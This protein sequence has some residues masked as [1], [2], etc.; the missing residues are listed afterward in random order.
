MITFKNTV[1]F[2]IFWP[3]FQS[4]CCSPVTDPVTVCRRHLIEMSPSEWNLRN[5]M[6]VTKLLVN[7]SRRANVPNE[8]LH[9][10]LS[11]PFCLWW[12]IKNEEFEDNWKF[13]VDLSPWTLQLLLC[14]GQTWMWIWV[15]P[16]SSSFF[17]A[18]FCWWRLSAALSWYWTLTA[19]FLLQHS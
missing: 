16:S 2:L 12:R 1:C 11:A 13:F 14:P 3:V 7:Y 5:P 8:A 9:V 15:L 4:A 19:K 18:S 6:I 17:S 10:H